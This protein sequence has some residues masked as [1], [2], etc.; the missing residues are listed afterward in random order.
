[1]RSFNHHFLSAVS[2]TLIGVI[3][4]VLLVECKKGEETTQLCQGYYYSEE[5]GAQALLKTKELIKTGQDWESRV[6]IITQGILDG[7][8]LSTF[9]DKNSLNVIRRDKRTYAGYTVENVAIES[10]PGVFL[11]GALYS[12]TAELPSY[13]GILSPHGHWG[14]MEDY[15]RFRPD[16][17]KRCATLARMGAVV[18]TYDMVGYGEM[19]DYGWKHGHPKLLKQQLWNSIRALD[20]LTSIDKIDPDRIGVTGASG[21]GTQTFL[22]AAVDDRVDVSVPV[23]M[24]SAHFFGGCDC[25]SGMPIHKSATHQTNNTE[26]AVSF[27]PKPLMLISDGDDW[28]SNNPEVEYP[29]AQYIYGL[30]DAR[31]NVEHFHIPDEGHDYGYSKRRP[32]YFFMAKHLQLN[33]EPFVIDEKDINED[34]I[35]IEPY[36]DF[37]VF[38]S[39]FPLPDYAVRNNDDVIW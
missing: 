10:L 33:I 9:S 12:P 16:V 38:T 20:F 39:E 35:V 34:D 2:T 18:F 8:E 7:T 30:Y 22:L 27:A 24:V 3:T 37:R 25:E 15:G 1:M 28:T 6:E 4:L 5:E 29:F 36:E 13:A 21:G 19:K 31:D 17:Q 32:M 14:K 11:T 23:V 26:I